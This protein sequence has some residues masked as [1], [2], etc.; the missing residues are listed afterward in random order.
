MGSFTY[1]PYPTPGDLQGTNRNCS[2]KFQSSDVKIT[3]YI[4]LNSFLK[5]QW[6]IQLFTF[7]YMRNKTLRNFFEQQIYIGLY[8]QTAFRNDFRHRGK[9]PALSLS[10]NLQLGHYPRSK[11]ISKRSFLMKSYIITIQRKIVKRLSQYLKKFLKK[12]LLYI[13]KKNK[14]IW[15]M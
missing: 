14:M 5:I 4:G 13:K 9:K 3:P 2:N 11:L 12:F 1:R 7:F 6:E 10:F 8:E 15:P